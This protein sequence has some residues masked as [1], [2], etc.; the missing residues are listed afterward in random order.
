MTLNCTKGDVARIV[1]MPDAVAELRD[2]F[3]TCKHLYFLQ[4]VAIWQIEESISFVM[5]G[6]GRC[7][8]TGVRFS[9]GMPV[10]VDS[11][12]DKYLRPI[13]GVDGD[14]ETLTWKRTPAV[15]GEHPK[16]QVEFAR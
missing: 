15:V 14:D 7:K 5:L 16:V 13:R 2:R 3:V 10:R 11:I 9:T 12:P 4:G 8:F 6:N 1:G